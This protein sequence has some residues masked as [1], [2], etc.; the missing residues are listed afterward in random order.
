MTNEPVIGKT[1]T[2]T[3]TTQPSQSALDFVHDPGL[4]SLLLRA[5]HQHLVEQR[6]RDQHRTVVVDD[7]H[8]IRKDRHAAAGDRLLPAGEGQPGDR[9]WRCHATAP[10]RQSG[11]E[12]ARDV[13]HD[14]VGDQRGHAA[15]RHSRT[16]DVAED[17]CV[18]H[19][20]RVDDSDTACRH[21]LD[22]GAGGDRR[23]P[24]L[25]RGQ[26]FARRHEAQREGPADHPRLPGTQRSRAA[27]PDIAQ[28]FLEQQRRERRGRNLGQD[29]DGF[30]RQGEG[31]VHL[32]FRQR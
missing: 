5:E 6:S 2:Q 1:T 7:D 29:F 23:S 4:L 27:K 13:A 8:V 16:Q 32:G 30:S 25:G 3:R 19:A 24:G 11:A 31:G 26:V 28:A 15:L 12:H 10:H 20:H 9:R 22:R 21:G 14:T 17:A 18:L